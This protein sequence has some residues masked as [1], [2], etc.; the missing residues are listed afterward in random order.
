MPNYALTD[1]T[2]IDPV[3]GVNILIARAGQPIPAHLDSLVAGGSKT[4]TAPETAAPR[5]GRD[6]VVATAAPAVATA[7]T[8]DQVIGEVPYAATI[9]GISYTPE[10]AIT[11]ADTNS[12][13][14]TV[15]NK[16]AAGA[17]TTVLG[18]LA[19]TAGIN[20]VAFDEKAV[21]LTATIAS[22]AVAAGDILAV[23]STAVGTGLA[24]P[25]G[26]VQV[27]LTERAA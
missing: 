20:A 22:R 25:G 8:G 18:T 15:V 13:T 19:L 6:N 10:A 3:T 21:T 24:D 12:R 17:G 2:G 26:L 4:A 23:V 5:I 27:E 14:L 9:T 7:V 1:V 16:G 11:G